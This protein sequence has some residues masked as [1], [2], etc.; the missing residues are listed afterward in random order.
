MAVFGYEAGAKL[1]DS[2]VVPVV[3]E[4]APKDVKMTA[5]MHG[6]P[7]PSLE[8][9]K[10]RR[11]MIIEIIEKNF[12]YLRK[13]MTPNIY[14]TTSFG[15][16]AGFSGIFSNFLFR[17]CFK[18]KHDALKTYASLATLPFLSTVVTY[19]LLVIDPLYSENISKENCVFRSSLIGIVCGVFYPSS[20]AFTKN[21]RLATKY[22]TVPLPP[23]GGVLLHWIRLCQTQM[24]LM[25][26]PL[27]FQTMFGILNGLYH[28]AI[29][30]GT[31]EKTIHEE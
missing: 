9:A 23:K 10:L 27:V 25:V 26:I 6:Q 16:T 28:Y 13:E 15:T 3:T 31:L 11:P 17:R 8:D 24:K 4:E 1:R 20:L 12:D 29:F 21:G 14:Q 2:G 18:V 22:H 7:S 19:K 5:S 30:E